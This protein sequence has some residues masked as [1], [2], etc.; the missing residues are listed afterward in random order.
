MIR[1]DYQDTDGTACWLLVTQPEHA[2]L[3]GELAEHWG[4]GTVAPLVSPAELLP[5]VYHHDDG[6]SD[7]E[8]HP[9]LD[10]EHGRPRSFTE[11]P[12]ERSL[13]IW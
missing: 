4:A 8:Q 7:W 6:W 10:P 12:L 2:R 13:E 3:A 1:R 9:T 5:A 11:M